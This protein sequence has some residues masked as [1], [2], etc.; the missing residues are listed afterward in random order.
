M[1]PTN[2]ASIWR[3]LITNMFILEVVGLVY[4]GLRKKIKETTLHGCR[5]ISVF[6]L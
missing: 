3:F 4:I 5:K 2:A 6:L 1:M